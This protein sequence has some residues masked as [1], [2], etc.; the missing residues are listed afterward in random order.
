MSSTLILYQ[1]KVR[2][3]AKKHK[4]QKKNATFEW[5][6]LGVIKLFSLISLFDKEN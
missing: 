2:S 6:Y 1:L 3:M 4:K 5:S